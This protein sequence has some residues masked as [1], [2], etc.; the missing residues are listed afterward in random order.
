M[1]LAQLELG[2]FLT[3]HLRARKFP[4]AAAHAETLR[5]LMALHDRAHG[6]PAAALAKAPQVPP[7]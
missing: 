7:L 1:A 4:S 3:L 6:R 2:H 5:V